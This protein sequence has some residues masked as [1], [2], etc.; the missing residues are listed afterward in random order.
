MK[1]S[2]W[3]IECM[4]RLVNLMKLNISVVMFVSS[5]VLESFYS[6]VTKLGRAGWLVFLSISFTV[7]AVFDSSTFIKCWPGSGSQYMA[8]SPQ[9]ATV[10][11]VI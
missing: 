6:V 11:R 5:Y 4:L 10:A 8:M 2:V 3:L 1:V 7:F 9:M